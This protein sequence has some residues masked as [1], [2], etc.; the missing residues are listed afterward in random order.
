M[1]KGYW[2]VGVDVTNAENYPAY[3][4][5]AQPAYDKYGARFLVRGGEKSVVEGAGRD[6]VVVV[7]FADIETAR[8]CYDSPEYA[9]ARQI[10]QA[11]AM[12]DFVIVEGA[13]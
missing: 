11:N 3:K 4:A 13:D 2:V 9:A 6:R 10:R 8:A 7:E 12:S 5:A 1:A